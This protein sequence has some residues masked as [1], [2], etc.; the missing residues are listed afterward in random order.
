MNLLQ[1]I[2]LGVIQG[3]AEFLPISSSGHLLLAQ[4]ALGI[5]EPSLLL[6]ILLHV[7]T[8]L[9]V[10]IV[11]WRDWWAMLKNPFKSRV[12]W[13]LVLASLPA[14]LVAV[15]LGDTLD[16]LFAKP[17]M[18]WYLGIFF[19]ITALLL[20]LAERFGRR[21]TPR[22]RHS[23]K[24]DVEDIT[25][26]QALAMG[27]M[28]GVALLPGV[29]RSGSTIVG[30]IF[31][32]VPRSVATKFSFMMSVPAIV[33][34]LIFE[35][36]DL[37]TGGEANLFADGWLMILISVLVAAVCGYAAIRWMLHL[38]RRASLNWF[39]LYV[40]ILGVL[41]LVDHFFFHWIIP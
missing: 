13:M 40:A 17:S 4:A 18:H 14:M 19:L 28:Q 11:F 23:R 22:G 9:A 8:L 34:S 21:S 12:F 32:G 26:T 7:G 29:S 10:L 31:S 33:G 41:V 1:A 3:L 39:A 27:A 5:P 24:L 25:T 35:T 2:V 20:V 37:L 30:G 36:K 16:A 15:L 6:A 38:V